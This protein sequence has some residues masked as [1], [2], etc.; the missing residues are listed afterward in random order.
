MGICA[1]R[2]T[3]LVIDDTILERPVNWFFKITKYNKYINKLFTCYYCM[4]FWVSLILYLAYRLIPG[5]TEV[6]VTIG[7]LASF[8]PL[9]QEFIPEEE[10]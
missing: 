5:V 8:P 1:W 4:G 7:A 6:V 10:E 3:H 2:S 9:I